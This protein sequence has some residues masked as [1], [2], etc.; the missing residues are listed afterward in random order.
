MLREVRHLPRGMHERESMRPTV[1]WLS[2]CAHGAVSV[3]IRQGTVLPSHVARGRSHYALETNAALGRRA[4]CCGMTSLHPN[5]TTAPSVNGGTTT[6]ARI[7]ARRRHPITMLYSIPGWRPLLR[8]A[9]VSLAR[10]GGNVIFGV[11]WTTAR[12]WWRVYDALARDSQR[13]L[14]ATAVRALQTCQACGAGRCW[15]EPTTRMPLTVISTVAG[16][17]RVR[18]C[19]V[20]RLHTLDAAAFLLGLEAAD[21]VAAREAR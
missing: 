7:P 17:V 8:Q 19:A 10:V 15:R 9:Q 12:L 13:V 4:A 1:A 18:L 21:V 2:A 16:P 20:C 5:G 11:D 3:D 14:L 6:E